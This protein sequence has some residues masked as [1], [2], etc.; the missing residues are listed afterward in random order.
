MQAVSHW[1]VLA[2]AVSAAALA[3]PEALA[4]ADLAALAA[5]DPAVPLTPAVAPGGVA[6]DA[7]PAVAVR[8]QTELVRILLNSVAPLRV[9]A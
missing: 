9:E 8:R 5:I 2:L 3:V 6:P 1:K 4:R 7:T